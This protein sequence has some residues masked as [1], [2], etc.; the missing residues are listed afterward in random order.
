MGVTTASTD[1]PTT[2][3]NNIKKISTDSGTFTTTTTKTI[4][5]T[6]KKC[7]VV[8]YAKSTYDNYFPGTQSVSS[9]KGTV[10]YILN[11]YTNQ[12]DQSSQY[13]ENNWAART[14]VAIVTNCAGA[15]LTIGTGSA[16]NVSVA[17]QILY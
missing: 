7:V 12:G 14:T 17:Y 16:N 9:T 10:S 2:M 11:N 4:P 15:T 8:I 5:S 6:V 3:A 1:S 13:S